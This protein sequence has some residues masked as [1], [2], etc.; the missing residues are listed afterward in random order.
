MVPTS[1]SDCMF[2]NYKD[3]EKQFKKAGFTN[4]KTKILYD[5]Y[6]GWTEEGEVDSVTINGDDDFIR[7][8]IYDKDSKIVITYHMKEEDDPNKPVETTEDE[9]EDVD[10]FEDDEIN[11][12]EVTAITINNNEEFASLMRITDQT[13]S[14]TIKKFVNSHLGRVIE[15]DGCIALMMNHE[16]YTTRFDVGMAGCD[17]D[18]RVY[19]P[20]FAFEDVNFYDMNVSGS[21]SVSEGMEFTIRAKIVGYSE[22]GGYVILEPISLKAR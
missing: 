2:E 1:A 9:M 6:W 5:I 16:N 10:E 13:D 3:I 14:I 22:D 17:Y 20:L 12:D 21:D 4:I 11:E 7:G 18:S 19:G 15:F 8:D